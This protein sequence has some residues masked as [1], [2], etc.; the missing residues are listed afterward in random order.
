MGK[1]GN[2]AWKSWGSA[3]GVIA[4]P[5]LFKV[6]IMIFGEISTWLYYTDLS[7]GLYVHIDLDYMFVSFFGC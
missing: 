5:D 3:I 2:F 6:W 4:R 1:F 7:A